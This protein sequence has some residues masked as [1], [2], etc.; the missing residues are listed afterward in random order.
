MVFENL[1]AQVLLESEEDSKF[2]TDKFM[3]RWFRE[4]YFFLFTKNLR[5]T[6]IQFAE[7]LALVRSYTKTTGARVKELQFATEREVC[8]V[9]Q[10]IVQA[11][12]GD[13]ESARQ[14]Y[15]RIAQAYSS[16][17]RRLVVVQPLYGSCVVSL[18]PHLALDL[19][20]V[21]AYSGYVHSCGPLVYKADVDWARKAEFLNAV[22]GHVEKNVEPGKRAFFSVYAHEDFSDYDR[23]EASDLRD[24]LDEVKVFI[25]KF[26]MGKDRLVSILSEMRQ[27][28]GERLEIPDPGEYKKVHEEFRKRDHVDLSRTIWLIIDR[29]IAS[30]GRGPGEERYFV[31]YDQKYRNR[32]PYQIFDE[33]KPGWIAHTTMPHS[34]MAA[35][36]NLALP[37]LPVDEGGG[38][39]DSVVLDPFVGSGT[40]WFE[41]SKFPWLGASGSDLEVA[42]PRVVEDN[43][44][45]FTASSAELQGIWEWLEKVRG[46]ESTVVDGGDEGVARAYKWAEELL[47]RVRRPGGEVE[48]DLTSVADLERRDLLDRLVLYCALRAELRHAAAFERASRTRQTAFV[49]E[50]QVLRD[51]V[52][53]LHD[54]R[55]REEE[56][57]RREGSICIFQSRYSSGCSISREYLSELKDRVRREVRVWDATKIDPGSC[58]VIITDPPYGFN[59]DEATGYLAE[60]Y[61]N[62]L[63]AMISALRR[64]GQLLICLIDRSR[65]GRQPVMC[66]Q[67]EVV[68]H[69]VLAA[70][71][72]LGREIIVAGYLVPEPAAVFRAPFYW[73][74]ERAL[75]RAVLHFR[76]RDR[77]TAKVVRTGAAL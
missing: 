23:E 14:S 20:S 37:W 42:V 70:A 4:S 22:K 61:A 69:Q 74:S 25:E 64:D 56:T 49:K 57:G 13:G 5:V 26:F 18:P 2:S 39:G 68:T 9:V 76:L 48:F 35:M 41:A 45:I 3:A 71:E 47:G 11:F 66:V 38:V 67:K 34:L 62:G 7:L 1:L 27:V 21:C 73:E 8:R 58:D 10:G 59:T 44:D 33:N 28:L 19:L 40:G 65:I 43:L 50:V 51:Q 77:E 63:R 16:V 53:E 36:L 72:Q 60:L 29:S 52:Q 32:N 46:F 30:D 31:C 75:R 12:L 6:N 15:S 17:L 55:E 24:G 54:L